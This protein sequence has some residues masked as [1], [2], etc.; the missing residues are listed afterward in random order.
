MSPNTPVPVR[1]AAHFLRI[2]VSVFPRL[3]VAAFAAGVF[4]ALLCDAAAP[5]R[6]LDGTPILFPV[7]PR[8]SAFDVLGPGAPPVPL[9]VL[10]FESV[11]PEAPLVPADDPPEPLELCATA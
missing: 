5:E 3:C 7:V 9:I 8:F 2:P 11:L 10:P 4:T 1:G 6:S